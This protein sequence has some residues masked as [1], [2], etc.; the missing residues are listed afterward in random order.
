MDDETHGIVTG[1]SNHRILEN[2]K[3]LS[4]IAAEKIVVSLPIIPG[5]SDSVENA[6]KTADFIEKQRIRRLRILPYHRLGV[7]K[8]EELGRAYPHR[9]HDILIPEDRLDSIRRVY[10][11]HRLLL[12]E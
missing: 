1:T 5:V 2:L 3:W 8:Y 12:E 4:E 7:S 10:R 6:T 11:E 9:H